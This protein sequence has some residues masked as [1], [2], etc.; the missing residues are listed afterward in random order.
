MDAKWPIVQEA[1]APQDCLMRLHAPESK[2]LWKTSESCKQWNGE[3]FEN[4]AITSTFN[5]TH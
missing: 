5:V 4:V 3:I 1:N 2:E